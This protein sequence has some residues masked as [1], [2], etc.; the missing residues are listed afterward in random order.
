MARHALILEAAERLFDAHGYAG[1]GVD[2]IGL[3]A[4]VTGSAIYRHFSERR[5]SSLR[6][7]TAR[8]TIS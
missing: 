1:V 4:G 8:S 2:T 7:S 6:C 3:E 5:R